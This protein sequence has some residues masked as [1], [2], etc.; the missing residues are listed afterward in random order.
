MFLSAEEIMRIAK[1][2]AGC[3]A[4]G[5]DPDICALG[6]EC[7][8]GE[9]ICLDDNCAGHNRLPGCR[10]FTRDGQIAALPEPKQPWSIAA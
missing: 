4:C 3:E 2:R 7:T 5:G 1:L 10:A 6:T 8:T 9:A